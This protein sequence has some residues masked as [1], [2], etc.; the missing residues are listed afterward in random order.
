MPSRFGGRWRS[1]AGDGQ[2]P[3]FGQKESTSMHLLDKENDRE[4]MFQFFAL[5]AFLGAR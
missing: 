5:F 3:H 1:Q 4:M 2:G